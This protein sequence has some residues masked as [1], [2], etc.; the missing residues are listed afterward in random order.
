MAVESIQSQA[1]RSFSGPMGR[2]GGANVVLLWF[3]V[4]PLVFIGLITFTR[5]K[6]W[7]RIISDPY[8][9]LPRA[10]I[11]FMLFLSGN[12]LILASLAVGRLTVARDEPK[13]A[14]A[15]WRRHGVPA[16]GQLIVYGHLLWLAGVL[17]ILGAWILHLLGIVPRFAW[18]SV[19][20]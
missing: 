10:E 2:I 5:A 19:V 20:T 3:Y 11:G 6:S 13:D 12:I 16:W 4:L 18:L 15:R 1:I 7:W 9:L 14:A 17:W 8:A